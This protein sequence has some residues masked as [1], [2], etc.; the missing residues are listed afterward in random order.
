MTDKPK[1]WLDMT[2]EEKSALLLAE[3][4]GKAIEVFGLT[5]PDEWYYENDP[6]FDDYSAYRI[7][8]EPEPK[9]ET[10]EAKLC[11]DAY[12]TSLHMRPDYRDN[13]YDDDAFYFTLTF[14]T[15]DGKF[16]PSSIKIE[17]T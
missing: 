12:G 13:F 11:I 6:C 15:I 5:Y 3:H 16:D 2:R 10:V 8:P 4:E 14:D 7:E 9:R 1:I 17:D